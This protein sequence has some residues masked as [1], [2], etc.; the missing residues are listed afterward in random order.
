MTDITH[1]RLAKAIA[2]AG[3][4]S[5]RDAESRITSGRVR[6]DGVCI[7]T[8]A[9][10]VSEKNL[11]EVD[12]KALPRKERT[13][14]WLFHKP[15]GVLCT[16]TDPQG[17][18]TIFDLLPH[19]VPRVMSVGRLDMNS[20]GLLLL[21]NDGSFARTL[22]LPATGLKRTYRVR[23][24]GCPTPKEIALLQKG[25]IVDGVHYGSIDVIIESGTQGKNSWLVLSLHEGKNRE[26][27]R[28]MDHLGYKVSRLIRIR[29]GH[30]E[31]GA[32]APA[33]LE[34]TTVK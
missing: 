5:R 23:V 34:E 14:L 1:E 32:L 15:R 16:N 22:E 33:T 24:Y 4:C 18:P 12:G 17:R 13:R 8:P 29:Y 3:I 20:E 21:T 11:I 25:I 7:T 27:R 6:V 31:L 19:D 28:V 9:F 26:I 10:N 30:W 2:R